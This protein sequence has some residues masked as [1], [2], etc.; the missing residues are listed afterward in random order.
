M[1]KKA[2]AK[3]TQALLEN[4]RMRSEKQHKVNQEQ[5]QKR[6]E[7]MKKSRRANIQ[8]QLSAKRERERLERERKMRIN[9]NIEELKEKLGFATGTVAAQTATSR[10]KGKGQR[11]HFK[12]AGQWTA[13]LQQK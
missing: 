5:Q 13:Q 9:R 4:R 3:I 7:D 2:D 1:P 6:E 8:R 11:F 10:N 12:T